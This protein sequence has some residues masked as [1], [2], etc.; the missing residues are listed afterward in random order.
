MVATE[1]QLNLHIAEPNI[2]Y[3]WSTYNLIMT[4]FLRKRQKHDVTDRNHYI[5]I[6]S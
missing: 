2:Q 1:S 4:V 5:I 6:S 3:I